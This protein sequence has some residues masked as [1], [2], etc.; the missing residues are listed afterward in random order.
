MRK[1]TEDQICEFVSYIVA[2]HFWLLTSTWR[3][4]DCQSTEQAFGWLTD[5]EQQKQNLEW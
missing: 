3:R 2:D 5:C 1:G 4:I